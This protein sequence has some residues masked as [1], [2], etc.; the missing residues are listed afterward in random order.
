MRLPVLFSVIAACAAALILTAAA[1]ASPASPVAGLP[2][3]GG[4]LVF[5]V[6][7]GEPGTFDCH[8]AGSIGV[9]QRISPHYAKL[10]RLDDDRFP[11]VTGDLARTWTVSADGLVYTFTLRENLRFHDGSA[12]TAR[13]VMASY[14]RMRNP[15]PGVVSL[16]KTMLTDIRAIET[17]DERTVVFRLRARNTAM[18]QILAMPYACIYSARLLAEDPSYPARRV[19][20]A[21]PFRFVRYEAGG[22]W[23]GTRFEHYHRPGQ[24]YLDGF[25]AYSSSPAASMNALISGQAHYN[26]IGLSPSNIGRVL[27]ARGDGVRIVGRNYATAVHMWAAVNTQRPPFDDARVRKALTLAFDRWNGGKAM[28]HVFEFNLPGGLVRPGSAE[29]RSPQE[30][31]SLPGF[32]RDVEA[33]RRE[34]RRLLAEAGHPQLRLSFL[35]NAVFPA[36]GVY[37]TDQL[38]QIGVTVDNQAVDGPTLVAR[39]LSGQYDLVADNPP[40]FLDEPLVQ[41]SV[42]GPFDQGNPSNY[43]RSSDRAFA[44]RYDRLKAEADPRKRR[45]LIRETEAYLLEQAYVLPLFWHN[46]T[47]AVS[48]D[49]QGLGDVQTTLLK[50]DLSDLWLRSARP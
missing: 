17:P 27:A 14:E 9:M 25:R 31:E 11:S 8:A 12:L 44:E 34:A 10:V 24:P 15:P 20:G 39:K 13:D 6:H 50:L 48:N 41:W 21:G 49:L 4:T 32:G 33:A 2:V 40:E 26:F 37:V 36:M 18:L 1:Q 19:M 16:R 46:W 3:R 23:V 47:R 38:R 22:D 28:Q 35:S 29:A 5:P 30:L 45:A 42:F 7:V 43:S